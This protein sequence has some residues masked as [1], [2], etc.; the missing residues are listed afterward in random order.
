V[1]AQATWLIYAGVFYIAWTL[2]F[3]WR[4]GRWPLAYRLRPRGIS[5]AMYSLNDLGLNI[6]LVAYTAWLLLGSTPESK[7]TFAGVTLVVIGAGLRLWTVLTLGPNWR[8]GQDD[9][10]Q[11]VHYIAAGPYRFLSH[12][13]NLA[14]VIVAMGQAFLTGFDARAWFLV[15]TAVAYYAAQAKAEHDFWK[16]RQETAAHLRGDGTV[17]ME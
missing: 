11:S 15:V 17:T 2:G 10:D 14:L 4:Y 13:I 5:E 9:V 12:P 8:M 1:T 16:T 6:S 3:R 7:S